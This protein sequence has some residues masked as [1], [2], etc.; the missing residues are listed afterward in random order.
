MTPDVERV[1]ITD[2]QSL[3]SW[4]AKHHTQIDSVLLVTW[5]AQN[6]ER[7][8][9]RDEVLDALIAYGW[10]DGR[11]YALDE[12]RTMQLISPRKQQVWARTYQERAERLEREQRMQP[13]G[14]VAIETSKSL[15]LWGALADVDALNDPVDLIA[16]LDLQSANEWWTNA[17][18][19]YRRNIL[20]WIASAKK[21]GTRNKRIAT[22]VEHA[23]RGE[24]VPNY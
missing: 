15:G 11:R 1:E 2:P 24:K 6:R 16:A 3:W 5:K 22:A 10:I 20:R 21:P 19:S 13:A 23:A 9:S 12:E 14:R 7:Y 18:P 17:A 8:V 4:L